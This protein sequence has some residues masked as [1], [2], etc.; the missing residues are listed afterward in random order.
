MDEK[1]AEVKSKDDAL[2]EITSVL[3]DGNLS[4]NETILQIK[5]NTEKIMRVCV[6]PEHGP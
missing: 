5:S 4:L 3:K 6:T 2:K 1:E